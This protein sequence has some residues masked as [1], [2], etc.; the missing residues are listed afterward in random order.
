M[1]GSPSRPVHVLPRALLGLVLALPA[2]LLAIPS[3][4]AAPRVEVD[5]LPAACG[6]QLSFAGLPAGTHT[7]HLDLK[8]LDPVRTLALVPAGPRQV[9]GGS[10]SRE[11]VTVD[12]LDV[13]G[14]DQA[15]RATVTLDGS[16][17]PPVDLVLPECAEPAV[18]PTSPAPLAS[19]APASGTAGPGPSGTAGPSPSGTPSPNP[20]GTPSPSPSGTP[21]PR[22]TATA[23]ATISSAPD[24]APVFGPRAVTAP[25]T[26]GSGV[27]ALS[28]PV[29]ATPLDSLPAAPAPVTAPAPVVAPPAGVAAAVAAAPPLAAAL[30]SLPGQVPVAPAPAP[31]AATPEVVPGPPSVAA[32]PVAE[33]G[34]WAAGLPAALLVTGAAAGALGLR[35]RRRAHS[36]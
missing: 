30:P 3:A 14:A 33:D 9:A 25:S 17:Q 2:G 27:I 36:S 15:Y 11:D 23:T 4:S 16:E 13:A 12:P 5:P 10:P 6:V 35:M 32:E 34:A 29:A 31:Q 19:P 18:A 21:S 24:T 20:S 7:V 1:S 26:A 22:A 8:A 28:G